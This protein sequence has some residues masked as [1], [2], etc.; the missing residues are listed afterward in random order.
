M[1]F[2]WVHCLDSLSPTSATGDTI[3]GC[4]LQDAM[5]LL[6]LGMN[7]STRDSGNSKM[8]M[9]LMLIVT[10]KVKSNRTIAAL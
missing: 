3:P 5:N 1:M 4:N 2:V 9:T 6:S 7:P 8:T 10:V